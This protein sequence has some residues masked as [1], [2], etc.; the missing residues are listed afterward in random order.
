[1][2]LRK[3]SHAAE[4]HEVVARTYPRDADGLIRQLDDADPE[5]RRRAARDLADSAGSTS[6]LGARLTVETDRSV[7]M[8]LLSSLR[9]QPTAGTVEVLLGLLRSEDTALRNDCIDALAAMPDLVGPHIDTL[10]GDVDSDVRIFTINLL[11]D[12]RHVHVNAWLVRVLEHEHHVNVVAAAIEVLAEVGGPAE[13]PALEA[14]R[15]RFA[16]DDFIQF[17]ANVAIERSQPS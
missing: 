8:V 4:I 9:A 14:V 5:V 16:H 11:G 3:Q 2:P 10:L 7:Q 6:A 1:M 15:A 17:V 13:L 12:L